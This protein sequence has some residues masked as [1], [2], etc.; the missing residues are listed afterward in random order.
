MLS[1]GGTKNGLLGGEAVVVLRPELATALPYVRKQAMQLSSKM[2]FV[3]AQFL[4]LLRDDLWLRNASQANAMAARLHDAVVAVPGL[5]V[6]QPRQANAVFVRLPAAAVEPLQQ[7]SPFY[8]W[9]EATHEARWMCSWDTTED[10][11]DS[12]VA[13]VRRLVPA[14]AG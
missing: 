12:F 5:Q 6:T 9:D 1:F 7:V 4:A 3:A 11:I 8:E 10:D 14:A 2:R 13:A